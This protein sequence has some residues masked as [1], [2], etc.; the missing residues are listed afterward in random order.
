[1]YSVHAPEVECISKGK[2][3]KK[4]EF[5]CKVSIVT[6][7]QKGWV[8]GIDAHHAN[9]YDGHT[10]KPTIEQ[11]RQLTGLEVEQIFIDKGYRGSQNHPA[12]TQVFLSERR[13]L[14]ASL[15]AWLKR[16]SAIEPVIGHLKHDNRMDR[17]YTTGKRWGPHERDALWIGLE[18]EKAHEGFLFGWETLMT[19]LSLLGFSDSA[20]HLTFKLPLYFNRRSVAKKFSGPTK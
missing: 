3:H 8:V 18:P 13:G 6:T 11:T 15:K 7:S 10:L 19:Q 9:P 20:Q 4:Y 12:G 1:M 14:K 5:G 2:A 16:R 17:N